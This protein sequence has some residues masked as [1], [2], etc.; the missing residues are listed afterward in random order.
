MKDILEFIV[1][2]IAFVGLAFVTIVGG[3]IFM[4]W[5]ILIAIIQQKEFWY[6]AILLGGL[7]VLV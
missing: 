5:V 4:A 7:Y 3:S 2:G 6:L 1:L